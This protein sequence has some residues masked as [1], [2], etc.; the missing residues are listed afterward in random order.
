MER[1]HS[2]SPAGRQESD[3][4]THVDSVDANSGVL[5]V[6]KVEVEASNRLR[7][8]CIASAAAA[9][10]ATANAKNKHVLD[11]NENSEPL[12]NTL[13]DN[14]PL[15]SNGLRTEI[16]CDAVQLGLPAGKSETTSSGEICEVL[17]ETADVKELPLKPHS[18]IARAAAKA[19]QAR[20]A[21]AAANSSAVNAPT[22][23]AKDQ[24]RE[25]ASIAAA[26]AKLQKFKGLPEDSRGWLHSFI[27]SYHWHDAFMRCET[28]PHEVQRYDGNNVTALHLVCSIG[29][30]PSFLVERVL[31]LWVD[32]AKV[33]DGKRGNTPLH[34]QCMNSQRSA[35]EVSYIVRKCP[36]AASIL[37]K[38]GQSA[39]HVA[40]TSNAMLPVLKLLVNADPSMLFQKDNSGAT[41]LAL[42]WKAYTSSIHGMAALDSILRGGSTDAMDSLFWRFWDKMTFLLGESYAHL[43]N[44]RSKGHV[45]HAILTSED[46]SSRMNLV[47]LSLALRLCPDWALQSDNHGN[48]PLHLAARKASPKVIKALVGA[49]Q[50]AAAVMATTPN[51]TGQTPLFLASMSH[52]TWGNGIEDIVLAAPDVIGRREPS[53]GLYPFQI[54]AAASEDNVDTAYQ[55]LLARPELVLS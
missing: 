36:L 18:A 5:S 6:A 30:A 12:L 7:L 47:L 2:Q 37:N 35:S 1:K 27:R 38:E 49:D 53:T 24:L 40:C 17:E 15:V 4:T 44:A 9:A 31:S 8:R 21:S 55:L 51:S 14:T 28:H 52:R 42:T 11:E 29:G 33:Q 13:T 32:A 23:A 50:N 54:A 46:L 16:S 10:A 45:I 25:A 19:G 34:L 3:P 48:S 39:L 43:D 41:P 20:I 22:N 26:Q